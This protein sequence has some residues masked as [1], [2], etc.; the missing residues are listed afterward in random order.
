M[1]SLLSVQSLAVSYG[2]IEAVRGVDF[3]IQKGEI[4]A[5]LGANGAGKSSTL[6]A[7]VGLVP[8]AS[9]TV[10]FKGED[11]TDWAPENLAPAGLT[12][13]PEG[14]RVFG[15][16]SVA[17]NLR[18]GAFSIK[19]KVA[20]E[21]AWERVYTLFPILHER[22][23]QFAGT[24]SGGQQQM[25]AVGRALMSNPS[26]L[27]L[28]EPSLGLAPKIV[29]QIFDLIALLRDQGVTLALVEQNVSMALEIADRGYVLASGKIVASGPAAELARSEALKSAYLGGE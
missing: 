13:S 12:L 22:R 7:L 5:F 20:L 8:V 25:L 2:P 16:L 15:A 24:L 27:L 3:D 1:A 18:M 9:G 29:G 14:R 23:D 21:A 10:S 26:L 11:I 4:V 6:N 19:D 17:E 28:D